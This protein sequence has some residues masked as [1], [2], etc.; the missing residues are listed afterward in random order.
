M[1]FRRRSRSS[2]SSA[3]SRSRSS[4]RTARRSSRS[5]RVSSARRSSKPQ[6]IRIVIENPQPGPSLMP[7]TLPDQVGRVVPMTPRRARF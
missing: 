6:E 7:P 4:F 1:A 5:R 3:S 2:R